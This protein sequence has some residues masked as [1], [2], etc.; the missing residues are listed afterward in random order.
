MLIGSGSFAC[1]VDPLDTS[2]CAADGCRSLT[3][4]DESDQ[5]VTAV[6]HA[7]V[8]RP[9]AGAVSVLS[10]IM[11]DEHFCV[12]ADAV[13]EVRDIPQYVEIPGSAAWLAGMAIY[14]AEPIAVVD[15]P[16]FVFDLARATVPAQTAMVVS[17][18]WGKIVLMVQRIDGLLQATV[19]PAIVNAGVGLKPCFEACQIA[20]GQTMQ[21]LN[22][23]QLSNS[24]E[25]LDPGRRADREK[26]LVEG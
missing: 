9:I 16:A 11:E 23:A 7:P 15:L 14:K 18:G 25:F 19:S 12:A 2:L 17:V 13:L 20:G 21:L 26:L 3:K 6:W 10:F 24:D 4:K 22:L 1:G 8:P 5:P